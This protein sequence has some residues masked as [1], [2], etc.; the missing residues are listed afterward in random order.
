ML[1]CDDAGFADIQA[2]ALNAA[3]SGSIFAVPEACFVMT[4]A[5][6]FGSTRALLT[7][8]NISDW[9]PWTKVLSASF[10]SAVL[11]APESFQLRKYGQF[12]LRQRCRP[13]LGLDLRRARPRVRAIAQGDCRT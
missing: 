3:I 5:L 12:G 6:P 13:R 10:R 2:T 1:G 4:I 9:P 8:Q 11:I 7:A